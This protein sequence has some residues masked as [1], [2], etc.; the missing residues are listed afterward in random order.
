MS[1]NR[2]IL[3]TTNLKGMVAAKVR[4]QD[5]VDTFQATIGELHRRCGRDV[6]AL[7]AEPV[8]PTRVDLTNP[9][10]T[11]YTPLDGQMVD[12]NALDEVAR[13]PVIDLLRRRLK[14]L[15]PALEDPDIGAVV[16]SWLNIT[17]SSDLLAVGGNPVLVNWGF[18]PDAVAKSNVA[19]EVHFTETIQCYAPELERPPFTTEE[20]LVLGEKLRKREVLGASS[21]RPLPIS[22][23][24]TSSAG[25][26]PESRVLRHTK[27]PR[28]TKSGLLA[29]LL[30]NAIAA[31]VLVSMLFF[32]A[33]A[34]NGH[35]EIPNGSAV[36]REVI[37][38]LE[39]QA[40]ARGTQTLDR[41]RPMPSD[42][43]NALSP[44]LDKTPQNTP[45]R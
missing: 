44:P 42:Q 18:L 37:D 3:R 35:A 1:D 36:S 7:F 26:V 39:E 2:E 13:K 38:A 43:P 6:A 33:H 17:S 5:A 32:I 23:S 40:K 34:P 24:E 14:Q 15:A 45:V 22:V 31:V 4:N 10:I 11:W 25:P 19:R 16:A 20:S 8:R 29:P 12:L 27:M 30:A 28:K 9:Q 21:V 41:N